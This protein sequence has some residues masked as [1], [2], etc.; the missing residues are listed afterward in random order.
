MKKSQHVAYGLTVLLGNPDRYGRFL[1][2][3]PDPGSNVFSARRLEVLGTVGDMKLVH[4]SVQIGEELMSSVAP[5]TS[6]ARVK[7]TP[8][9]AADSEPMSCCVTM[10][11]ASSTE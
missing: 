10:P 11:V 6:M 7:T 2:E 5:L 1:E 3:R 4:E 8:T 9:L